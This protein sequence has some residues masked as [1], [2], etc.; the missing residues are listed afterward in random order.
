M[1]V[2]VWTISTHVHCISAS[3]LQQ[4]TLKPHGLFNFSDILSPTFVQNV[5]PPPSNSSL[6]GGLIPQQCLKHSS[7]R[8]SLYLP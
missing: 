8:S 1:V 6:I 7:L 2:S 5:H 4:T 3:P